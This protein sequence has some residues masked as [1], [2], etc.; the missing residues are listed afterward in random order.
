MSHIAGQAGAGGSSGGSGGLPAGGGAPGGGSG[1][2][3]IGGAG[4]PAAACAGPSDPRLVLADQRILP[5]TVSET[6]NTV[7]TLINDVEAEALVTAGILGGGDSNELIRRFPPLEVQ[8]IDATNFPALDNVASHVGTY[9][10]DNFA[11]VTMCS[12]PTDTCATTYLD[13]LAPKAYRRQ[14]T[15]DEVTR[16]RG[17]YS[18]LRSPQT[19]NGYQV[20]FTIPEATGF[21][22]DAL[23]RS[24]QM[25]WRWEIGNTTSPSGTP[26]AIALTDAEL[27]TQLSFFLTDQPPDDTLRDAASAGRVRADLM[28]HVDRLLAQQPTRDWLR[29]IMETYFQ[30][31]TLPRVAIDPNQVP[32]FSPAIAADMGT[33][34]RKFLDNALWLGDLDDLLLSRTTFVNARLAANV[35]G[36]AVPAGATTTTFVGT[37]LPADRRS[38]LLT[39]AGF[40][41]ANSSFDAQSLLVPRGLA[42]DT[43]LLCLPNPGP[44]TRGL[45]D[46][47]QTA[48]EQAAMRSAQPACNGCHAQFDPY[49]L[50]LENYDAIGRYRT[51]DGVG[52]PIDAHTTLPAAVGGGAV[53]NG[54]EL[55]QKL[56][57]NPAF[58]NC[59]ARVLLQYAMV[60]A[61]TTVEVP[62][63]PQQ[64]GCAPAAVGERYQTIGG[65]TFADLVRST[66]ATPAFVL[67]RA[68]P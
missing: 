63:P 57:T 52:R 32:L 64:A 26:A 25:L 56:A 60:D 2:P 29:T 40:L 65:T 18:Q 14:L 15:S 66:A 4:G 34:T 48:Q 46:P 53:A 10:A 24:P 58:I 36:I 55:A 27:A 5:L 67:R 30:I 1:A 59:M 31:N 22:V 12:N 21:A 42:V 16:F 11:K 68:A 51:T 47:A 44:D 8:Y 45:P 28:A 6:L 43:V 62:L 49:G 54:V 41:T 9:V 13:K 38:G 39:N 17:L 50:A 37:T 23:L 7:R 3:G 20:T 61:A 33:E 35:Y 19:V